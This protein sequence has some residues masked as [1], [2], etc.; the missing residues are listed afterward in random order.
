MVGGEGQMS[1]A[2]ANFF[3]SQI[4]KGKNL[5]FIDQNTYDLM[6]NMNQAQID[7]LIGSGLPAQK[8]EKEN[9]SRG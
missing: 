8:A 4:Y 3:E 2:D 6:K 1:I 7:R 9:N 5:V